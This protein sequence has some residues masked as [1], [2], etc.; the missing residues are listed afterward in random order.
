MLTWLVLT[1][2]AFSVQRPGEVSTASGAAPEITYIGFD[3]VLLHTPATGDYWLQHHARYA[4]PPC[5][6]ITGEPAFIGNVG[7]PRQRFVA[8]GGGALLQLDA[9]RRVRQAGLEPLLQLA[10]RRHVKQ[11]GLEPPV[12]SAYPS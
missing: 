7:L 8:L 12:Q 3:Y 5:A 1:I 6:G 11:A 2:L 9:R 10:T 4:H